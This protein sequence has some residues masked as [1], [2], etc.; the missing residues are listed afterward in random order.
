[1]DLGTQPRWCDRG[2]GE[3]RDRLGSCVSLLGREAAMLYREVDS[4]AGGVD[5]V[6][7]SNL[8]IAVDCDEPVLARGQASYRRSEQLGKNDDAEVFS[9]D[10][11]KSVAQFVTTNKVGLASF[12][13]I[14][15]DQVCPKGADFNSC[16][17]VDPTNF[18]F[19]TV[20]QATAE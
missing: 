5:A 20:L 6:H 13:S 17:T 9:L 14:D 3:G 2:T 16:S 18:A 1:M 12:W 19:N 4:V 8:G 7:A 11:A 15:R 10:D